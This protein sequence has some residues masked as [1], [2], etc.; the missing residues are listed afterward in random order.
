MYELPAVKRKTP[1]NRQSAPVRRKRA[2]S[3]QSS[4]AGAFKD[5]L[6]AIR[7][8]LNHRANH[9]CEANLPGC[10]V[11]SGLHPHHRKRRSQGGSNSLDNLLL[12][13]EGCHARIHTNVSE[14]YDSG[15]L[16]RRNDLVTPLTHSRVLN[17]ED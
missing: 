16:I 3:R 7:G 1:L 14:S 6:D 17:Q 13:C 10:Y 2:M 4:K 15:L 9:R 11:W 12:C 5:E 8:V